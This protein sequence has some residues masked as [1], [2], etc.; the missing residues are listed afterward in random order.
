MPG[1]LVAEVSSGAQVMTVTRSSPEP[2]VVP[3]TTPQ[4]TAIDTH[5]TIAPADNRT[6]L[7]RGV[8]FSRTEPGTPVR[9]EEVL[10]RRL[11]VMHTH[12]SLTPLTVE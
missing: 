10:L 11:P 6:V 1:L 5:A 8:A 2:P 4:A 9:V 7:T 3:G 12:D